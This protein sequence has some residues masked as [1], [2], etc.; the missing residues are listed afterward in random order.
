MDQEKLDRLVGLAHE[1]ML[2]QNL[3]RAKERLRAALRASPTFQP[4]LELLGFVHYAYGDY[5]NAVMYWSRADY[6]RNPAPHACRK[7]FRFTARAL[8]RENPRAARYNLYAFAGTTPPEDLK[9][10]LGSLQTAYYRYNNKKSKLSGLACAPLCGGCMLAI[11][12]LTTILLGVGWSWFAWMGALAG[13]STGIVIGINTWS[14]LKASRLF[15][16]ALA[17]FR[18]RNG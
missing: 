9:E 3:R 6:W 15:R 10:T 14:Y 2:Q 12:G 18:E 11:L 1:D 7:V 16:E 13:I 5:R 17:P 8:S 4:A